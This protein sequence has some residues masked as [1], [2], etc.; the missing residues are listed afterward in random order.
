MELT[1]H[2]WDLAK[3]TGQKLEL[4][5]ET[6]ALAAMIT[7]QAGD[8]GREFG[9]F[10]PAKQAPEGASEFDKALAASGRNPNWTT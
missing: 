4:D 3:A 9:F 5:P 6:A 8:T 7:T 1:V 2:G 10:G